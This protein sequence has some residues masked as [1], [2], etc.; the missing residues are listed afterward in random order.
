MHRIRRERRSLCSGNLSKRHFQRRKPRPSSQQR[1]KKLRLR[2]R[3]YQKNYLRCSRCRRSQLRLKSNQFRKNRRLRFRRCRSGTNRRSQ[4]A[5]SLG[6]GW[7]REWLPSHFSYLPC[8]RSRGLPRRTANRSPRSR[9]Q[10]RKSASRKNSGQSRH[11]WRKKQN[12]CASRK[13]AKPHFRQRKMRV[14]RMSECLKAALTPRAR[15]A[16]MAWRNPAGHI[17]RTERSSK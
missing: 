15:L 7:Q 10:S 2:C 4:N 13:N 5:G 11:V 8:R 9:L 17:K 6:A 12:S 3:P 14:F 16:R 1:T